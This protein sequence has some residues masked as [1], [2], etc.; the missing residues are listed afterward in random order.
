MLTPATYDVV[1]LAARLRSELRGTVADDATAKGLYAVD[2]SNYR[3]VPDLVVV[4]ADVEDLAAAVTL[5]TAAGAA[6]TLRGGGTSMAG[7]AIGGVVIDAS[8]HVN[9]I[10]DIDAEA[11]T[12]VVEPGVVLTHLLAAARPHQLTFGADP[13]SASHATL[14]GMIANNACGAH[15]VAW[16]T[17]A[18]NVRSMDVLLADGSR[19]TVTAR[20]D[21]D[22]LTTR[23]GREGA[24]HRQLAGFADAHETAIRRRFGRFT[25]QIS[26]YALHELL[27]EHGYNVAA[28][29]CG[30]EGG[31]AAT[32]Q[33]TVALTPMPI[34]RVLCVLGFADSIASAECVP[35]VLAHRPLTMESINH[36]LVD[37]LPG[38]V[39]RAAIDAGLPDGRA[40]VLVEMGG[41]DLVSAA[42][43]AGKMIAALK[44]SGSPATA[45]LVTEPA[46][47]AV[48]WRCRTD[49]A[50]LAT[51][52]ADGAEAWGGWEDAAVPPQRLADYLRGLDAIMA[53]YGLSGA[54]YGHFGEGCM[55]MR[56]DFDL[57]SAEGIT[58]YR[59]F[60]EEA[61]D[62]VVS[63][64]GSV[65]G[66]HGDGRARSEMLGRMYGADGL[67]LL[68]GMKGI[69][70]PARLLNPGVIVEPAPLDADI[71]H[72]QVLA[73]LGA[74]RKSLTLFAY[75][76][77][78]HDFAQAQRRCVGIGKCRQTSG[79][80]MCPSY[81]ATR[82][83]KHSTRGRAHL[84]W[85]ML[86]GD[87][88]TEGWRSAEVRDALDL[89]LSCKGCLSD[90][91][92]NVDMATYKA[93]FTHHHYAGR[94][95]ARPLSH[96]SMG[97]LPLWSRVAAR[98]PKL[99]NR[100]A[101]GPLVKRLGGIAPERDIPAF[102]D[103]TFTSWFADRPERKG[104][105]GTVLLWP[106][107]FTNH[108]A[109]QVGRAAVEVLEDAGYQV[110]LPDG[111]VCC[112]LTWISTGQLTAAQKRLQK[113]LTLLAPHLEAG[114]PI[115]GLEP[116]CTAALRRDAPELLPDDPRAAQAAAAT[117]TF[118]EFLVA[119]GWQPPRL[120]TRALVQTHCHQHAVLGFDADRA[121]MAAAGIDADI[122]DSG[123]C[124]LAGNF[125]FER[126]HYE[127]SQTVGERV[128][129]PAV[130]QADPSTAVVADGF[131]CRTQIAQG[132]ERRAVH[133]AELLAQAL[134]VQRSINC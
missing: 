72:A 111:P 15:S 18:D 82:E 78:H 100:L 96:W 42:A 31:F 2:A 45:S 37:R 62:L 51:R 104:A 46:A 114:T 109:P 105:R 58:A 67:A 61:T 116:S 75:P 7:N 133:L 52:R 21:R 69:W 84:L 85:E 124:G 8:R 6:V 63:L 101:R 38:E 12:A 76:D 119:S 5:T 121:L 110:V 112:G 48:L 19:I 90:C 103:Q 93:E 113:S 123:C 50:G 128:L 39:R 134:P 3:V 43:A 83:E 34:A 129:L 60:V 125:G 117:H 25:R 71:R 59:A 70:D 66:E 35:A 28:L 126:G 10:L 79:G 1:Q 118:A 132:T 68:A 107:S 80:V 106:D 91:P 14:G 36:Q 55:H 27:P 32:L 98:A 108:L 57:L 54:S 87:V 86:A 73:G 131:S 20:G 97:W 41:E 49:A 22:E 40:W 30:S 64:G 95:W 17:T 92:V 65:S 53:R 122:P 44:D 29:L 130:R 11:G 88:V 33:A 115:I 81:Q 120:D 77:D 16:G 74:A 89:C 13:S 102:A 26:G 4:P 94:P 9:R 127:V 23:P 99:A 24:L 47:Q 56:I